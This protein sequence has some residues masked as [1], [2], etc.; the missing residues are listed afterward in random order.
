MSSQYLEDTEHI[1]NSHLLT[2]MNM[3]R[4][5][6]T[7]VAAELTRV[8]QKNESYLLKSLFLKTIV[9]IRLINVDMNAAS[10]CM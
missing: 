9:Q 6:L 5:E 8:K 3:F 10:G 2:S 7:V 4:N 1:G